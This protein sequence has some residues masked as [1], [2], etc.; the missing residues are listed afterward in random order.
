MVYFESFS[1]ASLEHV[2][3]FALAHILRRTIIVYG[4]KVVKS[5]PWKVLEI[6]LSSLEKS[7]NF[8]FFCST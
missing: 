8:T 2:H 4:V 6:L 7:L 5:L 3:I 1:G